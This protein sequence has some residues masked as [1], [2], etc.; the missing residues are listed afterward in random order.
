M[1]LKPTQNFGSCFSPRAWDISGRASQ[2]GNAVQP[3]KR[4]LALPSELNGATLSVDIE[5]ITNGTVA[6]TILAKL[7]TQNAEQ[8][9][10]YRRMGES[11]KL[12]RIAA[13]VP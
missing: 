4:D 6:A 1:P 8:E 2:W 12:Q 13:R 3:E 9:L 7:G 10:I 5:P 11:W